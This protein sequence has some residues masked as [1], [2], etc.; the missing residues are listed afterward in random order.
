VK[1]RS[2]GDT[3]AF[4]ILSLTPARGMQGYI[5]YSKV[6]VY[7]TVLYEA[8]STARLTTCVVFDPVHQLRSG[9]QEILNKA[10][11]VSF[12]TWYL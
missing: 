9:S 1:S 10:Y 12:Y 7:C 11:I 3:N 8:T 5:Q 6:T 4:L 2:R